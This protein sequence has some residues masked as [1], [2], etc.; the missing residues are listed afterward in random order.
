MQKQAS[1][2]YNSPM[3]YNALQLTGNFIKDKY[4]K[5]LLKQMS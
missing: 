1:K 3:N 4:F 2:L 5:M